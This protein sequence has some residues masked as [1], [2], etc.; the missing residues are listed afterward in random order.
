M[1]AQLTHLR[2][3]PGCFDRVMAYLDQWG[4]ES[5]SAPDGPSSSFISVAEDHIF[6]V[7]H[8]A[9]ETAYRNAIAQHQQRLQLLMDLLV[10]NHG[11]TYYGEVIRRSDAD[12]IASGLYIPPIT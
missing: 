9:D 12:A 1:I 3:K 5:E 11:P 10:E 2:P 4:K 7:S 8:Y 6:V